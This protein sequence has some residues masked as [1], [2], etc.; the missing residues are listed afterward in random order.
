MAEYPE[1]E[2]KEPENNV[3][4]EEEIKMESAS[5]VIILLGTKAIFGIILPGSHESSLQK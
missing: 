5:F 4:E 1:L 2:L 3:E